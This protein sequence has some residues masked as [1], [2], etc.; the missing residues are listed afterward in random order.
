MK[1]AASLLIL[2]MLSLSGRIVYGQI[3][4]PLLAGSDMNGLPAA[5]LFLTIAPDARAAGLGDAGVASAPDVNSQHWNPAKYA[6]IDEKWGISS[7]YTPWL[8]HLLPNMDLGYLAAYY[9]IHEKQ[10][11]SA[12]FRFFSLGS[13]NNT[14]VTGTP[15]ADYLYELAGDLAYARKLTEHFSGSITARYIHS[16]PLPSWVITDGRKAR[17]GRSVAGDLG[18]YYRNRIEPVGAEARGDPKGGKFLWSIGGLLSNV[19]TPISYQEDAAGKTPIPTN[20]RLGAC[21]TWEF[22]EFR[23][24]SLQA[25]LNKLLVPTPAVYEEDTVTGN[26]LLIRGMEAPESPLTGMLQSF[27][28]APGVLTEQGDYSVFR[29]ELHEIVYNLGLEFRIDEQLALRTGYVHEHA[30]K[31][32]R[33]YFTLGFG[34]GFR[35]LSLDLSC[36]LPADGQNSVLYGTFRFT[37]TASFGA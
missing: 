14:S 11:F 18:L 10:V 29:E 24:L 13:Y 22:Q 25:D 35:F 28:D 27:Y 6:F 15:T 16:D 31:G 21:I 4:F 19:G 5:A 8:T 32:N 23:A 26:L 1:P 12:S 3:S 7:T 30:T 9:R 20:L 17:P 36:L 33:Q 37:L 34:T 2:A